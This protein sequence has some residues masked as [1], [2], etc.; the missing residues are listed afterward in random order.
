MSS[1]RWPDLPVTNWKD[2]YETLHMWTQIAGKIRL[3]LAPYVNHWW[4]VALYVTPRGLTT[5]PIPYHE[6][7]FDLTFDF[8]DHHFL[9]C[10]SDG[11]TRT[12]L[13]RPKAVA[14]IYGE[15]MNHLEDLGIEVV[16]DPI[17]SEVA[18]PIACHEDFVHASYDRKSVEQFWS[19]LSQAERVLQ[20]FRSGFI[21]KCSP[22]HFFWGSFDL[23][24]T[25]FSGGAPERPGVDH[26]TKL[27][28]SHEVISCGFWLGSG[29]IDAPAFYAYAA[30]EPLGFAEDQCFRTAFYN[31]PSK[32]FIL[33]VDDIRYT[34]NP[35]QMILDFLQSTY[36]LGANLAKWIR[37]DLE[38]GL[39]Y[40]R[41]Q[42]NSSKGVSPRTG[43][44][45]MRLSSLFRVSE[46]T[47]AHNSWTNFRGEPVRCLLY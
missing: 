38:Q 7:S 43:S 32:E 46:L 39:F 5:G 19:L 25:R 36:D 6:K 9:L 28:Y 44:S 1:E 47:Q 21:G 23:A 37:P 3:K 35:D 24:V 18:N 16:I 17:P 20:K 40:R 30:P 41:H 15:L 42:V 45:Q 26:I 27:A 10:T 11:Q 29:N 31:P 2:T 12:I 22:V 13:L 14:E 8:L 4:E 34:E 33:M